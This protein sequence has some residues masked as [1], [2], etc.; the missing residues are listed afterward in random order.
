MLQENHRKNV[1]QY[2]WLNP[3]VTQVPPK[4]LRGLAPHQLF[5]S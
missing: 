1:T 2:P 3:W 5:E 4:R